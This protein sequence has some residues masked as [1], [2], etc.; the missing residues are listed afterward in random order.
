MSQGEGMS[1]F[2]AWQ[3]DGICGKDQAEAK[4]SIGRRGRDWSGPRVL[5]LLLSSLLR[6][7]AMGVGFRWHNPL[8]FRV[9][10][11]QLRLS[12]NRAEVYR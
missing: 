4:G 11:H 8:D 10:V 7:V 6:L 5:L 12:T 2:G 1:P 9:R 3:R